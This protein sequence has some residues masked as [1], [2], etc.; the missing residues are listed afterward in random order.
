MQT[1][2]GIRVE[3]KAERHSK[4]TQAT[5]PPPEEILDRI[6]CRNTDMSRV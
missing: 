4:S 3:T 6:K 1:A 5:Q 2:V